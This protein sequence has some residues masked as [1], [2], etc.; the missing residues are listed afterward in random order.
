M[1][2][3]APIFRPPQEAHCI[4]VHGTE[5]CTHNKCLFCNACLDH[6]FAMAP[7]EQI[8]EDI[9][10]QSSRKRM[11]AP[12]WVTGGNPFAMSYSRRERLAL[13]VRDHL[14]QNAYIA[15]HARVDDIANKTKGELK[16]LAAL[17]IV[18]LYVGVESGNDEAVKILED[19]LMETSDEEITAMHPRHTFKHF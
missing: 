15:M 6:S 10:L 11:D 3:E 9:Q 14:P 5:G 4:L 7:P 13:V 18:H 19:F 1:F 2:L 12:V 16:G 17:G 8:A